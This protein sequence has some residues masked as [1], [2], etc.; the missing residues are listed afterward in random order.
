MSSDA[1]NANGEA[2]FTGT[3]ITVALARQLDA[4]RY[5]SVHASHIGLQSCQLPQLINDRVY[6][7]EQ[8]ENTLFGHE[9]YPVTELSDVPE[10]DRD[11]SQIQPT[12]LSHVSNGAERDADFSTVVGD[13]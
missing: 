6:A 4:T 8:G 7:P 3:P 10:M 11:W 5:K 9:R 1:T 12:I 13:K 2:A